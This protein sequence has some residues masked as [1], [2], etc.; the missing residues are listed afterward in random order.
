MTHKLLIASVLMATGLPGAFA[1]RSAPCYVDF[2]DGYYEP[3]MGVGGGTA[4]EK[5]SSLTLFIVS[6][7]SGGFTA[8]QITDIETAL[9][10]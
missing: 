2:G 3:F 8:G 7:S 4:W 1:Q 5:N 9:S 6:P 10:N